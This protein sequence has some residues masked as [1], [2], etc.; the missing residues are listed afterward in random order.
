[1]FANSRQG[2]RRAKLVQGSARPGRSRSAAASRCLPGW[3]RRW[4]ANKRSNGTKSTRDT[5]P[6]RS[7]KVSPFRQSTT[8]TCL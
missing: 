5:P 1:V 3:I 7:R 8:A 4:F 2:H 6:A